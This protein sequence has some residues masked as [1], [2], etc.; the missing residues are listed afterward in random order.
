M[1]LDTLDQA[2][3]YS[4]LHPLFARAFAFLRSNDLSVLPAGSV[5]IDEERLYANVDDVAGRGEEGSRVEAHRRYI[6]IQL[7]VSGEERIGWISLRDCREPDGDFAALRDIG[8]FR[9]RPSS[10]FAV[11][12]GH[13]AIFWP[14]DAHAPLA[15]DGP[16]RKVVVKVAV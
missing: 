12:P 11:P 10:W 6:D 7:T 2:D 3:R 14:E 13:F 15:G 4:H 16:I 8:F 1:I 9:D 5:A